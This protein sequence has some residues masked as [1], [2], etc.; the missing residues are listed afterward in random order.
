MSLNR[1]P[2]P[3]KGHFLLGNLSDFGADQMAYLLQLAQTYG[4]ITYFRLAQYHIYLLADSDYVREVLVSQRDKFEKAALDKK[5]LGKFLGSGLLTSDGAF[6]QRQRRLAQ[7]AFHTGRIRAYAGAMVDYATHMMN[8]FQPGQT[9]DVAADMMRLTMFIVSKTLFDAD[10]VTETGDTAVTVGEAIHALQAVSNR[11]YRR[12][13]SW[14][15]WLPTADNRKRNRAVARYRQTINDIIAERRATA[16][17]GQIQD[18][19]DLLS[20]LMLA[21]DEDGG[22]MDDRQ[23]QDEVA[24]LFAAGHETTSNALSWT[25]YLLSQHP[26]VEAGLHAE[27]DAVLAGRPPTL[28][29][30]PQLPYTLQIIK[31]AMR[32]YPPAWILNGR[33]A[34]VDAEI[35]GY[36]IPQGSTLFISPYVMHR[37]PRYFPQPE[38]FRPE[39]WT[40]DMEKGLPKFAYM[41]FGGGPRV[42]IGNAFAMMEAHLILATIAQRYRL[43][44]APGTVIEPEAQIT[45]SPRGG[46]PMMVEARAQQPATAVPAL[47]TPVPA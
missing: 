39:R 13:F 20:M 29:D 31:E 21:Q 10:A 36:T 42:C 18:N 9:R 47:Q 35:G 46:L 17:N 4:G 3:E 5:I 15:N 22:F 45:L 40:P 32:L 23:L 28:D 12:G 27:L 44:L 25:W 38:Q 14:P 24:T 16:V 6:H 37:L 43:R 11:D 41:P 19:G 1:P 30:L 7:P 8:D 33:T 34:I 2:G 26:A